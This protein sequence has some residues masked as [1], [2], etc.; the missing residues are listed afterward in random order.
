[1]FPIVTVIMPAYNCVHTIEQSVLSIMN[2]TMPNFELLVIDDGSSDQTY[3]LLIKLKLK[4]SR[5]IV[6]KNECNIGVAKTRNR[7]INLAKGKY[8]AFLDSDDLW[9]SNKLEK[10]ITLLEKNNGD[11]CFTS[12]EFV[13]VSGISINRPPYIVPQKTNYNNMLRENVVGLSTVLVRR[14]ILHDVQFEK[15]WF[16]ED[17]VLW[18]T[19]LRTGKTFWG[20][21]EVLMTYRMGG[22][23]SDKVK[24][25]RERWKIYRKNEKLSLIRSLYFFCIYIYNG[26]KKQT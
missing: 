20:I 8:I 9:K 24:A 19:L 7:G 4:D 17:Y 11:L 23:S 21:S 2:Q 15:D 13:G 14:D 3:D 6:L 5:I 18:L 16:H 10:Q 22:R 12:Y 26:L 1:M 25:A